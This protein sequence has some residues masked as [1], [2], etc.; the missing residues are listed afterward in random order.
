LQRLESKLHHIV[1]FGILP[2]FALVN[3]GVEFSPEVTHVLVEPLGLGILMGLVLGKPIGITL[4]AWLA[5]RFKMAALPA[6][7]TW[8]QVAGAGMLGGIGFTMSIFIAGLGLPGHDMLDGAKLTI[9]VSSILAG[10]SGYLVLRLLG[11]K[12]VRDAA[13]AT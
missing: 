1:S 13:E 6:G 3:A 10:A 9:L 4:F 8:A 12:A 2:L 11:R 5:V 7:T